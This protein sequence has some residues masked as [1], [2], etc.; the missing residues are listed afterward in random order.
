MKKITLEVTF[1]VEF[2]PNGSGAFSTPKSM[3]RGDITWLQKD[4]KTAVEVVITSRIPQ[5]NI[6]FYDFQP[7]GKEVPIDNITTDVKTENM[8]ELLGEG[9]KKENMDKVPTTPK[10]T[11]KKTVAKKTVEKETVAESTPDTNTKE[12][13]EEVI[14]ERSVEELFKLDDEEKKDE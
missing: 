5:E 1:Y 13:T 9:L 10:T 4:N 8:D 11:P 2:Y 12:I 3:Q 14:E 7:T 6:F